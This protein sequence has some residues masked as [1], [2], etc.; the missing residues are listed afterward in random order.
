MIHSNTHI[1]TRADGAFGDTRG[2]SEV[3]DIARDKGGGF[4]I[5]GS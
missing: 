4:C 3:T 2:L 1:R 5:L